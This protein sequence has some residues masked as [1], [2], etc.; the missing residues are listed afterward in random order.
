MSGSPLP[1]NLG[2]SEDRSA[3]SHEV[4]VRGSRVVGAAALLVGLAGSI[5]VPA[6][7]SASSGCRT[8]MVVGVRGSGETE[9]RNLGG[10][11]GPIVDALRGRVPAKQKMLSYGLPYP[12]QA[13]LDWETVN[14][15]GIAYIKS[16]RR[17]QNMLRALLKKEKGVDCFVLIG[18][19]QGAQVVGDVLASSSRGLPA[20]VSRRTTAVLLFGDPRFTAGEPFNQGSATRSG[21]SG[22]LG[23]RVGGDLSIVANRI[24]SWCR[25]DD[26]VCQQGAVDVGAHDALAYVK[27]Y[28]P[29][30]VT[31]VAEH[32][33]WDATSTSASGP[34]FEPFAGVWYSHQASF[35]I[36]PDGHGELFAQALGARV[37]FTLTSARVGVARGVV[38]STSSPTLY[39]TGEITVTLLPGDQARLDPYGTTG[40]GP[41]ASAS[42]CGG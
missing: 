29:D 22:V 35:T 31:F 42:A 26:L 38:D 33:H 12:A 40:C 1:L 15:V 41:N 14:S 3:R 9:A 25:A 13:V 5:L 36:R 37:T 39:P 23:P 32:L 2:G 16:E 20:A 11:A 17:G 6:A 21:V 27:D 24:Q 4:I 19:S 34:N 8:T 28:L 10:I 30:A 7:A 18:Y